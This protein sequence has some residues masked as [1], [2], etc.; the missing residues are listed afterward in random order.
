MSPIA[1]ESIENVRKNNNVPLKNY[2]VLKNKDIIS[3][4][5]SLGVIIRLDDG[6]E[7]WTGFIQT[8]KN[9]D[10]MGFFSG[11]TVVQVASFVNS[12]IKYMIKNQKEGYLTPEYLPLSVLQDAKKYLGKL[13]IKKIK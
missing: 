7:Y 10:K 4:Y 2:Y 5:D 9:I 13:I 12:T 8:K 3:G 11:P 6:S 1:R